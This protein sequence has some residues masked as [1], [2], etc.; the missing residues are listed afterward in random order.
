MKFGF[1]KSF[2]KQFQQNNLGNF[3]FVSFWIP[4]FDDSN[5]PT[6]KWKLGT[7]KFLINSYQ[8]SELF[9]KQL[10]NFLHT[11]LHNIEGCYE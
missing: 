3:P 7:Y 11:S 5:W 4:K 6:I 9:S 8:D 2:R 1:L 10:M